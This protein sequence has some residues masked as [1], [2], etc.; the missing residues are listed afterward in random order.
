[1]TASEFL[2][3]LIDSGKERIKSPIASTF[4]IFFILYNWRPIFLLIFSDKSI[5]NKII[6]INGGYCTAWAFFLPLIYTF[7]Y[8]IFLPV[9]SAGLEKLLF[10]PAS[11]RR[12]T[13]NDEKIDIVNKKILLA[14]AELMLQD[15]MSRN[16]EIRQLLEKIDELETKNMKDNEV[17]AA[18]TD[19]YKR[20]ISELAEN[21]TGANERGGSERQKLQKEI[22]KLSETLDSNKKL[23]EKL[24]SEL[25]DRDFSMHDLQIARKFYE[26]EMRV[27]INKINYY[28][29]IFEDKK[30][31]KFYSKIE[32]MPPTITS[33]AGMLHIEGEW[34]NF[35]EV[36]NFIDQ[37][38]DFDTRN[39]EAMKR[40]GLIEYQDEEKMPDALLTPIGQILWDYKDTFDDMI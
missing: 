33:K 8:L 36:A 15:K 1:M 14:D 32:N 19:D 4:F 7:V 10:V 31:I 38:G 40:L 26:D 23:V 25:D 6:E 30:N 2:K 16:Q 11:Y 3:D 9:V 28:K 29:S 13:K 18:L 5:E 21:L 37:G 27:A 22:I 17:H 34:D 35:I 39:M 20:Q 12:S 24:K